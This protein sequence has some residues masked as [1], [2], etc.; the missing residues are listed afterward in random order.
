MNLSEILDKLQPL[1]GKQASFLLGTDQ[2]IG[3]GLD[4]N[5]RK[6]EIETRVGVVPDQVDQIRQFLASKGV[7]LDFYFLKGCGARADFL[8]SA[9][10][11]IGGKLLFEHE[12]ANM[13]SPDVVHA[14]KEPCAYE[15]FIPGPFLRIGALHSGAFDEES[16]V[17]FL[18]KRRNFSAIFDGSNIGEGRDIPIRG[19]MSIFA[20]E[21]AAEF[22]VEHFIKNAKKDTHVVVSGG[23]VVGR[24]SVGILL[25]E[26]KDFVSKITLI[27]PYEPTVAR[28]KEMYKDYPHVNVVTGATIDDQ[29]L[30]GTDGVILTA[31][32]KG[33][34]APD[35]LHIDQIAQVKDEAI[36]V[37]VSIDEKG[38]IKLN[39]FKKED[40]SLPEVVNTVSD[41]INR[42]G[43]KITYIADDHMPKHKPKKASVAHGNAIAPYI[44]LL[45]YY[46]AKFGGT[47]QAS[48]YIMDGN[49]E[50]EAPEIQRMLRYLRNGLAFYNH[51]PIGYNASI[52]SEVENQDNLQGFFGDNGIEFNQY[53]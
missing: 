51:A 34:S 5:G 29:Y 6:K 35:V 7:A 10:L 39:D 52:I 12:L 23:G 3:E 9:Y 32:I 36:I 53:Q 19:A 33:Q 46:S 42:L 44:T 25:N 11:K 28:L 41:A 30:Q 48:K 21:I 45:L 27:E 1:Q 26:G 43:K 18:F 22:T 38:G 20:G 16:G 14:L 15:T 49:F 24:A 47:R 37:D 2:Y 17:A 13:Q 31:F 4:E 8:D 50:S 40:Y